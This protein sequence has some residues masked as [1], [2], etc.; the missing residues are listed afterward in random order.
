[1]HE[2]LGS[3]LPGL[4]RLEW[5]THTWVLRASHPSKP[6]MYEACMEREMGRE[7][8]CASSIHAGQAVVGAEER[9]GSVVSLTHPHGPT[10]A[11]TQLA[12]GG[13]SGCLSNHR[14]AHC[15]VYYGRQQRASPPARL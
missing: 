5:V 7:L 6:N 11:G 3:L 8:S 15:S 4:G 2:P 10:P 12:T 9:Y 14:I 13:S 1:M